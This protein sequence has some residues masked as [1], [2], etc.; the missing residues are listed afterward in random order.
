MKKAKTCSRD[1]YLAILHWRNTP[2]EG[3]GLSAVQRL[4]GRRTET[5]LPTAGSLLQPKA[6][7][8]VTEKL[9]ER[10]LKQAFYYNRGVKNLPE[11]HNGDT[12]R[13][14]PSPTDT[15][16]KWGKAKLI[17]KVAPRSYKVEMNGC[18][19][20]RNRRHLIKTNKPLPI[21]VPYN[22]L[23]DIAE[24]IPSNE[25][26]LPMPPDVCQTSTSAKEPQ[27]SESPL[28]KMRNVVFRRKYL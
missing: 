3:V 27:V 16:K 23:P 13:M 9:N 19:Y 14:K 11:L 1:P 6:P 5:V 8:R 22:P 10:K 12:V 26:T 4:F 21:Q 7:E 18:Y 15:Q 20:R 28:K 17:K 24:V 25:A 2:S